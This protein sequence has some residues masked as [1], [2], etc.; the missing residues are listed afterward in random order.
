MIAAAEVI[1]QF[2]EAALVP[3]LWPTACEALAEEVSAT[4]ATI[5]AIDQVGQHR[6]V[7]TPNI[8][9]GIT[10]FSRDPRRLENPRPG[11][12]L[13]RFPFTFTRE[14]DL[15][16]EEELEADVVLNEFIRPAGMN[17]SAG[18][19]FQEPTG[20]TFMFDL[21]RRRGMDHYSDAE[22]AHL[23]AIK[24]DLARSI[25][26][27]SRL[28][29]SEAK[30]V[31]S[32]LSLLGLPAMVLGPGMKVMATNPEADSLSQRVRA[33]AFDRLF[34]ESKAASDL[35]AEAFEQLMTGS[36]AEVQS[37]PMISPKGQQPLI[38]HLL[39][40]RRAAQDIFRRS[41]AILV[42][43]TVGT[44]GPPDMKVLSGLFD[45]T[46]AEVKVAR[47]IAQARSV[48][49]ISVSH[50]VSVHTVR[51]HVKAIMMKTGTRRQPELISLLLGLSSPI[52]NSD[53]TEL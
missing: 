43:T 41:F 23:N 13:A 15:L 6:F 35:L 27:A 38:L 18:C 47:E 28:A 24:P 46:P 40:V 22:I 52:R 3:E 44:I 53:R 2:Y 19:A 14:L 10:R 12:A 26:L 20:H 29:F 5:F 42:V 37:V 51:S 11:R 9:D 31:T 50:G 1:D 25:F 4:T 39:P 30:S 16:T 21:L 33:G 36:R 45:L 32:A 48:E 7:C 8:L 49:N 34:L 17:W